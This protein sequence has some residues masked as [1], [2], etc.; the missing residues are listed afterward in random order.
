MRKYL[1][2]LFVFIFFTINAQNYIDIAS[3][4]YTNTPLN[5]FENSLDNTNIEELDLQLLYPILVNDKITI[6]TALATN[7][8]K[9]KL[10][11][12]FSSTNLHSIGLKLGINQIYS[13]KWSGTYILLPKISSDLNSF[14][15]EDL[16]LG[17]ITLFTFTKKE[18]LKY[19]VGIY[20]N[21]EIYGPLIAPLLGFY[22][23]SP[24]N[25]FEAN[26]ILPGLFDF[27]YQV[28]PKINMGVNFDGLSKTYNLN[29]PRYS[30][31]NEYVAK[32]SN[33]FFTYFRFK[34]GKSLHLKTKAGYA[35]N[36]SYKVYDSN[37]KI[38]FALSS[39]FFEDH[40]TQ[41]NSN[42]NTGAIFKVELL[43]RFQIN[44]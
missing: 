38:N 13:E 17:L 19:K 20:A 15:K 31:D 1:S 14:S 3:F 5:S 8:T 11:S 37:D 9:L 32:I 28:F 23:A 30:T 16:Q 44:K 42:F 18:N 4:S 43:Y 34:L 2:I 24:N 6:L 10:D 39:L 29:N 26:V 27:N 36:R 40:R 7:K 12:N 21:T 25:K 33:E 22:Y 35:I 41:L